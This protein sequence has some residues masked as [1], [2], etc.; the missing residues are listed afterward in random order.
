MSLQT[1]EMDGSLHHFSVLGRGSRDDQ[2]TQLQA[3]QTTIEEARAGVSSAD[4]VTI[5]PDDT[6]PSF[7]HKKVKDEKMAFGSEA[8][9]SGK[10]LVVSPDGVLK[11]PRGCSMSNIMSE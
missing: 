11:E 3:G 1:I 7:H 2:T 4:C 8:T 5:A 6:M 10:K 9:F